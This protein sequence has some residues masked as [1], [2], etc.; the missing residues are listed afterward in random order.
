MDT[1]V[2][3][4]Q[5]KLSTF[6]GN[7]RSKL[8]HAL[9]KII[10]NEIENNE[11]AG[12]TKSFCNDILSSLTPRDFF[13]D[14]ASD[15]EESETKWIIPLILFDLAN[16]LKC[17]Q[18]SIDHADYL[19]FTNITV[20]FGPFSVSRCYSGDSDGSETP[21]YSV[22]TKRGVCVCTEDSYFTNDDLTKVFRSVE[23]DIPGVSVELFR[24]F[25]GGVFAEDF[26]IYRHGLL[27]A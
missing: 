10:D 14:Y 6:E 7:D 15:D 5:C 1:F 23:Q 24:K 26:D 22:K 20:D 3:N 25:I 4:F 13:D 17:T 18:Y 9:K 2:E 21:E 12:H 27:S 8:L 19:V 11:L 16:N